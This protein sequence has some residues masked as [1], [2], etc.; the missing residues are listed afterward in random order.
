MTAQA[1][2]I[3]PV[4]EPARSRR[5]AKMAS[6]S[7]ASQLAYSISLICQQPSMAASTIR[8]V[9]SAFGVVGRARQI[10]N[11]ATMPAATNATKASIGA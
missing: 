5:A 10:R 3:G 1:P 8:A 7:T 6:G 2:T 11:C 9:A 4:N